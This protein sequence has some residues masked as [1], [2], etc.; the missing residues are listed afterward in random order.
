MGR[1]IGGLALALACALGLA[2]ASP[3]FAQSGDDLFDQAGA[4]LAASDADQAAEL[5]SQAIRSGRLDKA[6]L[7]QAFLQRGRAY[8]IAASH[9]RAVADFTNALW[10]ESLGQ[11]DQAR[12]HAWR[13]TSR[14]A[15]GQDGLARDDVAKA[16][17]LDPQ[18]AAAP[19]PAAGTAVATSASGEGE[20]ASDS[21]GLLDRLI[22]AGTSPSDPAGDAAQRRA[23][24]PA[25]VAARAPQPAA[26]PSAAPSAAQPEESGTFG[27]LGSLGS[28]L[29]SGWF[30]SDE[31]EAET[32]AA[33]APADSGVT[34][35]RLEPAEP[36]EPAAPATAANG[37]AE[38]GFL[39]RILAAPSASGAEATPAAAP[40]GASVVAEP[41]PKPALDSDAGSGPVR[42]VSLETEA[43]VARPA[44]PAP[45]AAS[46]PG[47]IESLFGSS[48]AQDTPAIRPSAT[49]ETIT[50]SQSRVASAP[51]WTLGAANASR[52]EEAAALPSVPRAP[53]A[54][55]PIARPAA[56]AGANDFVAAAPVRERRSA[57]NWSSRSRGRDR[58]D[59]E[60]VWVAAPEPVPAATPETVPVPV[61]A[62]VRVASAEASDARAIPAPTRLSPASAGPDAAAVPVAVEDSAA[63]DWNEATA[64]ATP[65]ALPVSVERTAAVPTARTIPAPATR[66]AEPVLAPAPA[67]VAALDWDAA[68]VITGVPA[69]EPALVTRSIPEPQGAPVR[70]VAAPRAI[71][72]PARTRP[73]DPAAA[74][75]RAPDRGAAPAPSGDPQRVGG[76]IPSRIFE[77]A[78]Q[79]FSPG[80]EPAPASSPRRVTAAERRGARFQPA[81]AAPAP[82]ASGQGSY[83]VQVNAQRTMAEAEA[84]AANVERRHGDVLSGARP[85]IIR[86]DIPGK[87]TYYR[88]RVGP[89]AG[90]QTAHAVCEQLKGRGADCFAVKL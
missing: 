32:A 73:L 22:S 17:G 11:S 26:A 48:S 56:A 68:T 74:L 34:V 41:R 81:P 78:S 69:A 31:A 44:A 60:P 24:A 61:P 4:A 70:A 7:S 27:G 54:P 1:N 40:A 38:P 9:A 16:K 28:G 72:A 67:N 88:V 14:Q 10:L 8:Q 71:P 3:A 79:A 62:P 6:K 66:A 15:L 13:A 58:R 85:F 64:V 21:G 18:V 90:S 52:R 46:R 80:I 19:A 55:A 39:S 82:A 42:L 76:S 57:Q 36:A 35:R 43:E 30:G 63:L 75:A 51:P 20:A 53:A 50:Y 86:A 49:P 29:L 59:A 2:I 33:P 84:A 23:A 77:I 37:E 5:Y 47:L 25:R 87:G 12:A 45:A 65:A 89:Y 83:A